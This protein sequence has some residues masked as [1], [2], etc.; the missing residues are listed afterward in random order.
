MGNSQEIAL[1]QLDE[2]L[3]ANPARGENDNSVLNTSNL[4]A[5]QETFRQ[6][7]ANA[8]KD[9]REEIDIA[10]DLQKDARASS[11]TPN[12]ESSQKKKNPVGRPPTK[13]ITTRQ[14]DQSSI[15]DFLK[16]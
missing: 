1:T 7:I 2:F 16:R 5:I 11:N 9:I 14:L 4:L 3:K 8:H 6:T 12:L 13:N 10:Y 15:K